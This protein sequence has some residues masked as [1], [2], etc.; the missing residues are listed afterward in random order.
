MTQ[1]TH[2]N[3]GRNSGYVDEEGKPVGENIVN[4]VTGI[5]STIETK[6]LLQ[7]QAIRSDIAELAKQQ[8]GIDQRQRQ[9]DQSYQALAGY[10]YKTLGDFFRNVDARNDYADTRDA[11]IDQTLAALGEA[12]RGLGGLPAQVATLDKRMTSSEEDRARIHERLGQIEDVLATQTARVA[13]TI[14]RVTAWMELTGDSVISVDVDLHITAINPEAAQMFG[15]GVDELVGQSL[16]MLLPDHLRD[17]HTAH[18]AAFAQA[19]EHIRR[20]SARKPVYGKHRNGALVE[21]TASIAKH[22]GGYTATLRRVR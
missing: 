20:M 17:A 4:V 22:D 21:L 13:R 7:G 16:N 3:A 18:I 1:D 14:D 15:Y 8:A 5:V 12:V 9:N 11:R 2:P 10:V 6:L 19:D